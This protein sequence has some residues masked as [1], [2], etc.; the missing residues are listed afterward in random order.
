AVA[1][2]LNE[3]VETEG[4]VIYSFDAYDRRMVPTGNAGTVPPDLIDCAFEIPKGMG[5]GQIRHMIDKRILALRD[6]ERLVQCATILLKDRGKFVGMLA[7]F[8]PSIKSLDESLRL[9]TD[10]SDALGPMVNSELQKSDEKQRLREMETLYGV[11]SVVLGSE[12]PTNLASR[13][14]RE[15]SDTIAVDHIGIS[16][17]DGD[18]TISVANHGGQNRIFDEVSFAFGSGIA[19]WLKTGSPELYMVDALA[20][21]RIDKTTAM[22]KRVGSY[23]MIPL[24]FGPE[25]YGFITASTNR[26]G[27]ID[28]G[29]L[30]TL[31]AIAAETSQALGRLTNPSAGAS[32][33]MTPTEFYAAVRE[34]KNGHLVYLQLLRR[35]ELVEKYGAPAMDYAVRKLLNQLRAKLPSGGAI[36]RRDEGDYVAFLPNWDESSSRSWANDAAATASMVGISTPDGRAKIPLALRAKVAGIGQQN[37]QVSQEMSA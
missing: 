9:A 11:A 7:L 31:R 1:H 10:A 34:G 6:P 16:F 5:D 14:V 33:A 36:C 4:L 28:F 20:D 8:S 37:H 21:D 18:D 2:K 32:G 27:G 15:L 29:K 26:V 24:Q 17:L 30:K 23:C 35:D 19:G 22:K 13:V 12:S 25:P 3:E